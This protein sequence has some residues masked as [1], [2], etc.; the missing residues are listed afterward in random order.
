MYALIFVCE[1]KWSITVIDSDIFE[2]GNLSRHVLNINNIGEGKGLSL[3]NYLNSLNP[4][5]NIEAINNA[6]TIDGKLKTNIDLDK[7]GVI[8]DC[9]GENTK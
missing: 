1:I 4:H 3:C 2:V 6:L 8:I 9:T 5:T 7:Y